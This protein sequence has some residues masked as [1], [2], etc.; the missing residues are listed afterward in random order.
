ME[1]LAAAVYLDAEV[2][3]SVRSP[4]LEDALHREG[5]SVVSMF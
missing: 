4:R 5:R 3:L 2:Y 1:V